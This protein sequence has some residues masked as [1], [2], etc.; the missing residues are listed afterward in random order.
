MYPAPPVIRNR[1]AADDR[2]AFC[3]LKSIVDGVVVATAPYARC[4]EIKQPS[5]QF[6]GHSVPY[7]RAVD[8]VWSSRVI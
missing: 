3:C 6:V 2:N 8:G 5:S 1:T 4:Y 7:V